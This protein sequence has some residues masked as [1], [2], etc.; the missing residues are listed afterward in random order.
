MKRN[1]IICAPIAS[2]WTKS[3]RGFTLLEILIAI[4]ILAVV[5]SLVFGT[6]DGIF[7]SAEHVNES[8]DL[9]DM[10]NASLD[11]MRADLKAIHVMLYPR[12]T[13]PDA[14]HEPDL[15]RIEGEPLSVGGHDTA[16]IRFASLAHLP[17]NQDGRDGIAEIVYYALENPDGTLDLHRADHLYPYPDFEPNPNDPVV[18]EQLLEYEIKY[19]DYDGN[20]YSEWNSESSSEDF[21]TPVA[22]RVKLIIGTQENPMT[23]STRIA[24]PTF[25]YKAE[26]K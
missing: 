12:Y 23:F 4:F 5:V 24:L 13:P 15:Y 3:R 14:D 18:C 21:N 22:I 2:L 8:S 10:G 11:R 6:F 9:S 16:K 20:E 19:F 7:S 17:L 26:K 1:I 25:R